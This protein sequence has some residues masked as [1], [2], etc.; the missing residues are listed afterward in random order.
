VKNLTTIV[1]LFVAV[2]FGTATTA[3]AKEVT[4]VVTASA[5][6][7]YTASL[8]AVREME[9]EVKTSDRDAGL[10]ESQH[11]AGLTGEP[12]HYLDVEVKKTKAG[13]E[14]IVNARK[15]R[16][17]FTGGSPEERLQQF[18]TALVKILGEGTS[19]VV[20]DDK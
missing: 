17:A 5:N 16:L 13:S 1:V 6:D 14:V 20:K 2:L 7:V 8:K 3:S 15:R 9:F 10:I 12:N 4:L 11:K 19:V 18:R